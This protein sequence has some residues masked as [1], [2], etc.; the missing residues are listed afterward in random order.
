MSNK[1]KDRLQKLKLELD[2]VERQLLDRALEHATKKSCDEAVDMLTD[3]QFTELVQRIK[4]KKKKKEVPM[5]V[6]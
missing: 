6:A 4:T 2:H 3:A 5:E 1:V